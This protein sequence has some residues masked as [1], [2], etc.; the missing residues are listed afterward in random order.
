MRILLITLFFPPEHNA[1]TE[2]YTLG[3]GRALL[4]K[5]HDVQVLCATGWEAGSN[6]WNGVKRDIYQGLPVH[7]IHINWTK[8]PNPNQAL[9]HNTLLEEWLGT[10]LVGLKPDVVHVTSVITLGTGVLQA[11]R[12]AGIPLVLTLTDFWF[13]CPKIQLVQGNG[14]LCDGIKTAYDCQTCLSTSSRLMA[15]V[16]LALP[17]AAR[18]RFWQTLSQ[19]PAISKQP[20]LR[21][22][23]LNMV[24]RKRTLEEALCIPNRIFAPSKFVQKVFRAATTAQVEV[25][26][27]G[28]DLDWLAGFSGKT[29]S[30]KVRIG[31][32]GQIQHIKGVHV[33]IKAFRRANLSSRARL[34]IWGDT[35]KD[36]TY[37]HRLK[38]LMAGSHAIKLH[39]RFD[40]SYL[41]RVLAEIDVLVVPSLWYEN[42]PLVIQ[43]AF[44]TQTPVIATDLGGMAEAVTHEVNGLLFRRGDADDL[45]VQLRRFIEEPG[46][47][48]R[49]QKGIPEVKTIAEEVTELESVYLD[50]IGSYRNR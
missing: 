34:D 12:A 48:E 27:H 39:G 45:A 49:L 30:E 28:H 4:H 41:G 25:L 20:G 32:I 43:E 10:F 35:G 29:A 46:L 1:G 44:A 47:K 17:E 13:I 31:Y 24:E 3:L 42:A 50:L 11:V 6:Y 15:R 18:G 37:Y 40:R 9:Y 22:Y 36:R 14:C 33:L 8:S 21:G 19:Y 2:N 38:S 5:G 26:Y 7:R 16:N 23:L